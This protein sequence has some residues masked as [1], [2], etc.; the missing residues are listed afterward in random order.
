VPVGAL[1]AQHFGSLGAA[2]PATAIPPTTPLYYLVYQISNQRR[3]G[4]VISGGSIAYW[5]GENVV[6][7]YQLNTAEN[8]APLEQLPYHPVLAG[9][10]AAVRALHGLTPAMVVSDARIQARVLDHPASGAAT[11]VLLNR[12]PDPVQFTATLT[13]GG[14]TVRLPSVGVVTLPPASGIVLPVDYD[15][16]GLPVLQATVELRGFDASAGLAVIS[17]S[18]PGPGE[19]LVGLDPHAFAAQAD[20]HPV[21]VQAAAGG[22]RVA[23]PSGDHVLRLSGPA[24]SAVLASC[25]PSRSSPGLTLPGTAAAPPSLGLAAAGLGVAALVAVRRRVRPRDRA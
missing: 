15:L 8:A 3:G 19:V 12:Y 9:H 22:A 21:T 16:D 11:V 17:T 14:R 24:V 20:G 4:E 10:V 5:D 6:G 23:L 25:T 2:L 1:A 7:L 18:S 13:A